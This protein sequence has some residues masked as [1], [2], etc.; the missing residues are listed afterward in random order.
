MTKDPVCG[1]SVDEKKAAGTAV[2]Q[3]KTY[4]FCSPSCKATFEKDPG[5]YAKV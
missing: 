2:A 1:M 4:Y 5:K 3:G